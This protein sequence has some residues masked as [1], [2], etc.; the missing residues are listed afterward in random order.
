MAQ[1][2]RVTFH[3]L[4]NVPLQ[5]SEDHCALPISQNCEN[6]HKCIN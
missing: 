1:E 6:I 2:V 4:E 3:I 5:T